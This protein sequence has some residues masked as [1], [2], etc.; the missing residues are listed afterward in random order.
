MKAGKTSGPK[1]NDDGIDAWIKDE[2]TRMALHI[3]ARVRS[4]GGGP[5]LAVRL[6]S[7]LFTAV[8][9]GVLAEATETSDS[10]RD[11]VRATLAELLGVQYS[12]IFEEADGVC[13]KHVE[14]VA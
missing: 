12:E 10:R 7:D 1:L 13:R 14:R 4:V 6:A 5:E 11:A 9:G 8:A 3:E 2:A